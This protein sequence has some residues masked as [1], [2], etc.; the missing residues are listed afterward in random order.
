MTLFQ[1]IKELDMVPYQVK[2]RFEDGMFSLTDGVNVFGEI[3]LDHIEEIK[4]IDYVYAT[5]CQ[6][7]VDLEEH[8]QIAYTEVKQKIEQVYN[9]FNEWNS[10]LQ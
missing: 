10:K 2:F 1:I 7:E 5:A 9:L 3:Y 6:L 4:T 8:E